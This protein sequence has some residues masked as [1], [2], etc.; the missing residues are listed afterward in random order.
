MLLLQVFAGLITRDNLLVLLRKAL[1]NT[2]SS[3][4]L[5]TQ[6]ELTY[7]DLNQQFVTAAARTVISQQQQAALQVTHLRA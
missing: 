4:Q 3:E 6:P 2:S 1:V 5:L 7:E